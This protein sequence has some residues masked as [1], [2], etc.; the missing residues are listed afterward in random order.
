MLGEAV[1]VVDPEKIPRLVHAEQ[2]ATVRLRLAFL[3]I[4]T[5]SA[6]RFEE[7]CL[8]FGIATSTAYAWIQRWN[9]N[10]YDG[11][12]ASD[13]I[14]GRPAKLSNEHLEKLKSFLRERECWTTKEVIILIKEKF[15]I[16]ISHDRVSVILKKISE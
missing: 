1:R 16:D 10:G 8:S 12:K 15:G 9:E 4:F 3:H 13:N 5:T 14:G 2:D 11:L 6:L 7:C